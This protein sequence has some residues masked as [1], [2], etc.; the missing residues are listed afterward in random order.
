MFVKLRQVLASNADL[1]RKLVALERSVA[2]LDERTRRQFEEVYRAISA[3][4]A[5]PMSES[6]PIS[7]TA[8]LDLPLEAQ[9]TGR[10]S[11]AGV[12]PRSRS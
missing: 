1:A 2:T 7:F 9:K 8:D 3:L 6:R 12:P 10:S 4:M 11:A 5:S